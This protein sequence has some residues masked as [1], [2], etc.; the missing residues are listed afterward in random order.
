MT[1]TK[2]HNTE[3]KRSVSTHG[4]LARTN[5]ATPEIKAAKEAIFQK[6]YPIE[7]STTMTEAEKTPSM[8]EW[9]EQA[10]DLIIQMN[11]SRKDLTAM[12]M[13]T[14][15]TWRD[16]ANA[17]TK[18]CEKKN[19][20][21]LVFSAG[22]ADII[23]EILRQSS[24]LGKN[25]H[26]ISNR[27]VFTPPKNVNGPVDDKD[28]VCTAFSEPL[29]HVFNKNES[30]INPNNTEYFNQVAHRRNVM[31]MGDSLGDL[32]MA[33]GIKHDVCLTIGFCNHDVENLFEDYQKKFDIVILNDASF[34]WVNGLLSAME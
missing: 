18:W 29:I 31:L 12:V 14:P 33:H 7:I 30:A 3:G 9:W 20:P 34:E 17:V 5:K 24:M 13:E 19:V 25:V 32:K 26:V 23:E 11:I 28:Y 15:V 2:Y 22:L 16:G 21:L 10:H 8:I 27:M 1:L 4:I 6:Y